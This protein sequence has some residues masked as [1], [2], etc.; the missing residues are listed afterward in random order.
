MDEK[1]FWG[2]HDRPYISDIHDHDD[3]AVTIISGALPTTELP[4]SENNNSE[5]EIVDTCMSEKT[6]SG[7]SQQCVVNE[8]SCLA[9]RRMIPYVHVHSLHCCPARPLPSRAECMNKKCILL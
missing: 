6:L 9:Y 1:Q 2:T 5:M 4:S 8:V 3:R 7:R